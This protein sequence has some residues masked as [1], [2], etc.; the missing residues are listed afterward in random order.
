MSIPVTVHAAT[1]HRDV[2][3][4]QVHAKDGSRIL[5]R[6]ICWQEGIKVP[7]DQVARGYE[8]ADGQTAVLTDDD[9]ADL[10]LPAV[11]ATEWL[12]S[13]R[14]ARSTR[15]PWTAPPYVGVQGA[16]ARPYR[17]LRDAMTGNG[18]GRRCPHR[19]EWPGAAGRFPRPW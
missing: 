6:R 9:L 17:L 12:G 7:Y 13:S 15:S 16:G 1:E 14:P 4:H 10:P 5:Q 11:K 18:L 19:P 2:G 3:L 8:T